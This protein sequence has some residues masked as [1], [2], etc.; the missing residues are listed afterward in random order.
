MDETDR[1]LLYRQDFHRQLLMSANGKHTLIMKTPAQVKLIAEDP[2][3]LLRRPLGMGLGLKALP[4]YSSPP[5]GS[6]YPEP[7]NKVT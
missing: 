6:T 1:S 5:T 4:E 2:N 7:D 3:L